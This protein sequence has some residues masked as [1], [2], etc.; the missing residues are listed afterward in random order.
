M[1]SELPYFVDSLL[2]DGGE[3]L[4]RTPVPPPPQE[5]PC[6]SFLTEVQPTSGS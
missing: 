5:D 4:E 2:T 3:V 1:T 6:Y